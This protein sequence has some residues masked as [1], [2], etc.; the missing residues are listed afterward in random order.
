MFILLSRRALLLASYFQYIGQLARYLLSTPPNLA[1]DRGHRV[2]MAVGNGLTADVWTAFQSRFGIERISEFYASTEGNSN[3]VN[4]LNLPGVIGWIPWIAQWIY[5][6][7]VVKFDPIEERPVRDPVSGY[8]IVS[9]AGEVGELISRIDTRDPL[10]AFDGYTSA[11]DTEAKILRHVFSRDDRWFRSGDLVRKSADGLITFVDRVGDTFRWKGENCATTEVAQAIAHFKHDSGQ[12][13]HTQPHSSHADAQCAFSDVNV[14]GV[15]VPGHDGR[16]GM[17]CVSIET[18]NDDEAEGARQASL[19]QQHRS[20]LRSSA[21]SG[22][23]VEAE[24][25]ASSLHS[26]AL[27][28]SFARFSATCFSLPS[29]CAPQLPPSRISTPSSSASTLTCPRIWPRISGRSSCACRRRRKKRPVRSS[30]GRSD[31][32]R[33]KAEATRRERAAAAQWLHAQADRP[34][35]DRR[36]ARV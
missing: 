31:R 20:D 17:A 29:A 13:R 23:V 2:R 34:G 21:R 12:R 10:R 6:V 11:R 7:R 25:Q 1:V 22:S 27:C 33:R 9:G 28:C 16:A 3:L 36:A 5:P 24:S 35:G 15:S 30:S 14:Y 26:T 4:S 19:H 32:R 18:P 8:C